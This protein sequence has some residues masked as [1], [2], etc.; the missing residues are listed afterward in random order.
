M[1]GQPLGGMSVLSWTGVILA[2]RLR[3]FDSWCLSFWSDLWKGFAG[4]FIW[5]GSL[6]RP[7]CGAPESFGA[8]VALCAMDIGIIAHLFYLVKEAGRSGY[9]NKLPANF[10]K[11]EVL[12]SHQ[13]K[14]YP[15][16]HD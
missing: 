11:R 12:G 7:G 6:Y 9:A 16:I 4:C 1:A 3:P 5:P 2:A 14:I 13:V 15:K 8:L 10:T